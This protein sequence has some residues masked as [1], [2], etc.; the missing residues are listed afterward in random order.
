MSSLIG[1]SESLQISMGYRV[2]SRPF[3]VYTVVEVGHR[4]LLARRASHM[5]L[6]ITPYMQAE[7]KRLRLRACGVKGNGICLA[8]IVGRAGRRCWA[9]WGRRT[10]ASSRPR[11][12]HSRARRAFGD[13]ALVSVCG[14]RS[15]APRLARSL[16]QANLPAH[17]GII[18]DPVD[19]DSDV[20]DLLEDGGH[21][22]T[23][24]RQRKCH[25]GCARG[26][27]ARGAMSAP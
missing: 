18:A 17:S 1:V 13:G 21:T 3:R 14:F 23:P 9:C 25:A 26:E 27:G 6:G 20:L 16:R 8:R 19:G 15:P 12:T 7:Q 2:A 10:S 24:L 11:L 22:A 4:P 5:S